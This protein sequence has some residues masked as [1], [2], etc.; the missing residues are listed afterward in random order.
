MKIFMLYKGSRLVWVSS[1]IFLRI[2]IGVGFRCLVL[3]KCV[4]VL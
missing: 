2:M 4:C 3:G 1:M